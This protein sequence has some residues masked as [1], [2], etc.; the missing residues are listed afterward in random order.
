MLYYKDM[1]DKQKSEYSEGKLCTYTKFKFNFGLEKYLILLKNFEQRRRL[2]RLRISA[3]RL[4]IELGR[5]QGTL[6]Q[7]RV[8]VRC[9]SGEV[10]DELHFIFS[11][12]KFKEERKELLKCVLLSCPNFASLNLQDRLNW[13]MNTENLDILTHLSNY[14]LKNET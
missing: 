7:D 2:T 6:R 3:H 13:I 10:E 1:W 4:R 8:C 11:C 5:Y 14:I 9:T 12:D